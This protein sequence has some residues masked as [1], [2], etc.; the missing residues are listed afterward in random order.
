MKQDEFD[1]YWKQAVHTIES[2]KRDAA[3]GDFS[4]ACFKAQQ[5][6]EFALKGWIRAEWKYVTGHSVY[7]L[8]LEL[9]AKTLDVPEE[10]EKC[11]LDLDKVYIPS[12]YPDAFDA[13]SPFDYFNKEDAAKHIDCAARILDYVEKQTA[14]G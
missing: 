12:R 4:W 2:A 1:R 5:A 13:G 6:A 3:E 8:I 9:K 14:A 11:S 10:I 7:S